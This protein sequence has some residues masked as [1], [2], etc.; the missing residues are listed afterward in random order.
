VS[1]PVVPPLT[2]TQQDEAVAIVRGLAEEMPI[3]DD[4]PM[5]HSCACCHMGLALG[6]D[7]KT[8]ADDCVYIGARSFVEGLDT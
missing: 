3:S 8:H 4:G 2:F 5:H 1:E 6:N 7:P